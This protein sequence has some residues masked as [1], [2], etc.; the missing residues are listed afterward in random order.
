[1]M[2]AVH[3]SETL[4]YF[5][6]TTW[7]FIPEGYNLHTHHHENL[8]SHNAY[9]SLVSRKRSLR[10]PRHR[11]GDNIVNIE[12]VLCMGVS[13]FQVAQI[14]IQWLAVVNMV[15]DFEGGEYFGWLSDLPY[16]EGSC[17]LDFSSVYALT[18][19][20]KNV[21]FSEVCMQSNKVCALEI[22][23]LHSVTNFHS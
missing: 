22:R 20:K 18:C 4:V 6:K 7:R 15:M 3:T 2:E 21:K 19:N 5:I 10:R 13:W 23:L 8:K 16:Q 9:K 11:L 14:R 12:A 1:M 17:S